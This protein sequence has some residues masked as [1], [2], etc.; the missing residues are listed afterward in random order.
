[1]DFGYCALGEPVDN[2]WTATRRTSNNFSAFSRITVQIIILNQFFSPDHS[3]T[4]QLM[5]ELAKSLV[6]CGVAVSAIAS[7]GRYNGG[8]GLP[9]R[10]VHKGVRIERAWSTGT[11]QSQHHCRPTSRR[12]EGTSS[13]PASSTA[14]SFAPLRRRSCKK[15]SAITLIRPTPMGS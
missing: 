1:M 10:E 6:E 11:G 12:H 3:A 15:R 5:T 8:A 13:M 4:S 7:R 14:K 2:C 9:P